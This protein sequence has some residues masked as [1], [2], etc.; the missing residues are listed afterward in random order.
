MAVVQEAPS[1]SR[2]TAQRLAWPGFTLTPGA[3]DFPANEPTLTIP[4]HIDAGGDQDY[5][6]LLLAAGDRLVLDVDGTG[7]GGLDSRL[8][9]RDAD[10]NLLA[11][12]DNPTLASDSGSVLGPTGLTA[13]PRITFTASTGGYVYIHIE[14]VA[15]SALGA[16]TGAYLLHMTITNP[17][18]Q[19]GTA[20]ADTLTGGTG[21]DTLVGH[22]PQEPDSSG[23]LLSGLGGDDLLQGG[24]GADTL[25]GGAG[26]DRLEGGE[27][28]DWL[29]GGDSADH[30]LGGTGNDRLEGGDGP[31]LLE[32]GDGADTLLGGTD[33]TDTLIGGPDNDQL[34]GG[35]LLSGG[36][37]ADTLAGGTAGSSLLQ[38]GEGDDLLSDAGLGGLHGDG[39]MDML[40]GGSGAD[41]LRGDA[42]DRLLGGDGDDRIEVAALGDTLSDTGFVD[43]G[44]G[45]DTLVF[46]PWRDGV[47]ARFDVGRVT[48]TPGQLAFAGNGAWLLPG[49]VEFTGIESFE[50]TGGISADSLTGGSGNDLLSGGDGADVLRGERGNDTLRSGAGFGDV[51]VGGAGEDVLILEAWGGA[52]LEGGSGADTIIA[53]PGMSGVL[54]GGAISD[55]I[56]VSTGH[57]LVSGD[58]GASDLLVLDWSVL[59]AATPLDMGFHRD[60]SGWLLAGANRVDHDAIE[61]FAIFGGAGD[62]RILGSAAADTLAG[63]AGDDTLEGG[64]QTDL[65]QGGAGDD[66]LDGGARQDTLQGGEGADTLLGGASAD[67]LDGGEGA[68]LFLYTSES[69]S[70]PT[71][72]DEIRGF[73]R[74]EDLIRLDFDA[75]RTAA[76]M[77][78]FVFIGSAAFTENL[79]GRVRVVVMDGSSLRLEANTDRDA[80]PEFVLIIRGAV[81]LTAADLIL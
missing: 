28:N 35:A 26:A 68:D 61:R 46:T 81:T 79:P 7:A 74:G 56:R 50:V 66:W 43:G 37:G 52:L 6:R 55:E 17:L 10:S 38:G 44:D 32:G 13:D 33:G 8:E 29:E 72:P 19:Y 40:E 11:S 70:A 49:V 14:G 3:T 23:D 69:D 12:S 78:D 47:D 67:L 24:G 71:L 39:A 42:L 48:L 80:D 53:A 64:A 9:L 25:L 34:I 2:A 51:L 75:D 73:T 20:S 18:R 63:G 77:Q 45:R 1:S 58:G 60:G 27:G 41:T 36:G 31:D 16:S 59:G 57:F 30:L 21:A 15:G 22:P 62:E 65:L 5:F 54:S 76:G 4:G